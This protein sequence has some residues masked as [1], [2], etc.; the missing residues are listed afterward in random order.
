MKFGKTDAKIINETSE[1]EEEY[2]NEL[3]SLTKDTSND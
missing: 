3:T 2:N 1:L